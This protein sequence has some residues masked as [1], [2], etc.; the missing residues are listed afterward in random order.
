MKDIKQVASD[1]STNSCEG[2]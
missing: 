2:S 1:L